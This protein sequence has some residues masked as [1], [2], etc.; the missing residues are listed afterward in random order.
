[1]AG[2][3]P[4]HAVRF[5]LPRGSVTAGSDERHVLLP[6]AALDDLVLIAGPE[7]ACS[8]GRAL[9]S[10]IGKRIASRLGGA[11]ALRGSSIER[12]VTDIARELAVSGLG[13]LSIERW[14]R[15]LVIA[16]D[17]PA[18]ADLAF[19][20]SI[21]EGV[22]EGA[23]DTPVRCAS[24]GREGAIVRVLVASDSAITRARAM[25]NQGAAWGDVLARLHPASAKER[26]NRDED[27][28]P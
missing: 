2:F 19:L 28:G 10:S 15:A 5:D 4:T 17:R 16:V 20:A 22:L 21:L 8:V 1:M 26:G 7:A 24:L 9:G 23:T 25:L 14:G 6:C 12:V 18:V 11:D 3:D 13:A 27:G